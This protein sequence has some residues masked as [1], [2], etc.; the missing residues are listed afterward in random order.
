MKG[1]KLKILLK[2]PL[3]N[4]WKILF[5]VIRKV[6]QEHHAT[7]LHTRI[8]VPLK[9]PPV[10]SHMQRTL[11]WPQDMFQWSVN[12]VCPSEDWVLVFAGKGVS[13]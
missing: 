3:P 5:Q 12:G 2:T 9:R 6:A 11:D 1:P 7:K 10:A 13:F 8:Q 4:S